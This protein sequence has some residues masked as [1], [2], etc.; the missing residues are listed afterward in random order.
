MHCSYQVM[1]DCWKVKKEER[2]TFTQ[3]KLKLKALA[4]SFQRASTVV[5]NYDADSYM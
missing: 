5:A 3:I 1:Q 4:I 2:P